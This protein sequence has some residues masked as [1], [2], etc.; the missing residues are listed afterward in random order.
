MST[1]E[2][3]AKLKKYSILLLLIIAGSAIYELPYI[4][5]S[6]Y[7]IMM[8]SLGLD[9]TQMGTLMSA[10]GIGAMIC[11]FPG[12]WLADHLSCKKMLTFSLLATGIIGLYFATFPNY[13]ISLILHLLWAITTTLT[14]WAA[15]MK[16]TRML[17]DSS[18][19]GKMFGILEGGR[20]LI[21][22]LYGLAILA[23]FN[24]LG[25][26][27][28]GFRAV[29]IGYSVVSILAGIL[30]LLFLSDPKQEREDKKGSI[31]QDILQIIKMPS[32]WLIALIIFSSYIMY[33]AQSYITP[34]LTELFQMGVSTAALISLIRTYFIAIFAGPIGGIFADKIGSSTK[35]LSYAFVV[36]VLTVGAFWIIPAS[37]R[38]LSL[39]IVAMILL[40]ASVF[41]T[42]GIYFAALDEVKIPLHLSGTAIGFASLI[43][44]MPEAFVYRVIGKWLD[45]NPGESGY[46]IMFGFM[47]LVGVAG[48]LACL[49]LLWKIK[50]KNHKNST[51]S[52][53]K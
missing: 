7:D 45:R 20:G 51:I 9:H 34:Y 16:A 23:V 14:F 37:P 19:Q 50:R 10:Y 12:G 25:A 35:V 43:G 31:F 32:I 1:D 38:F 42:R 15:M 39:V 8:E 3:K 49:L 24:G 18:E 29:I 2:K 6:Y 48:F 4:R 27:T 41:V 13:K 33:T 11:Y 40:A 46:K 22:M 47:F 52:P 44:F 5:Y 53:P 36:I 28:I 21:P 26:A 30:V 17:G